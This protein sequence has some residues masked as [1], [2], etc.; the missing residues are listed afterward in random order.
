MKC[1]FCKSTI[2][3]SDAKR[4]CTWF[5]LPG[6]GEFMHCVP[7]GTG[8]PPPGVKLIR[9]GHYKCWQAS[10]SGTDSGSRVT[11]A[12]GVYEIDGLVE[13]GAAL[14]LTVE[15]RR[16]AYLEAQ[17]FTH[18]EALEF[19]NRDANDWRDQSVTEI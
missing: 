19:I 9:M 1:C 17:G 14:S 7:E 18:D 5:A 13:S 11:A 4:A 10:R 16:T 8:N 12:P 2:S 3:T 6:G 15:Q